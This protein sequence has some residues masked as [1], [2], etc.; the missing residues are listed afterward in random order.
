M[1]DHNAL[2]ATLSRRAS[3]VKRTHPAGWRVLAFLTMALPCGAI[4]SLLVRRPV[5]DWL[6]PGMAWALFQLFII[7]IAG[8]LAIRNA[9]LISIPGRRALSWKGFIPLALLWLG[10][11]LIN[12]RG[13]KPATSQVEGTNCYLFMLVVSVPMIVIMIGYLRQ[14]RTLF[15]VRS[16]TAAGAGTACMALV[17][18]SLCHPIHLNLLDFAQHLLAAATIVLVTIISGWRWVRV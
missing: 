8:T 14:T 2:I 10:S 4:A 6:Q 18:L 13:L 5:T 11:I 7:F 16:L 3:P 9:F 1:T 12:M 17:L 15:P